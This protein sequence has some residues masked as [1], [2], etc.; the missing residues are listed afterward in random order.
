MSVDL[1]LTPQRATSSEGLA[2]F[3]NCHIHVTRGPLSFTVTEIDNETRNIRVHPSG[4]EQSLL[5]TDRVRHENHLHGR[6]PSGCSAR[7]NVRHF[8]SV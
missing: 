2:L 5:L 8:K 1:L 3:S 7:A 6:R 4:A